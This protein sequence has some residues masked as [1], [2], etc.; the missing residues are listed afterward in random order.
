M[1]ITE[2]VSFSCSSKTD[3][4]DPL[5]A[6]RRISSRAWSRV[7][8]LTWTSLSLTMSRR[9]ECLTAWQAAGSS[10]RRAGLVLWTMHVYMGCV[11]TG[12]SPSSEADSFCDFIILLCEE[13]W[14]MHKY[15][16]NS[17]KYYC[18]LNTQM[19][20]KR[21]SPRSTCFIRLMGKFKYKN[22]RFKSKSK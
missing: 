21:N 3:V 6:M 9:G 10:G 12:A 19:G 14:Y 5:L 18:S 15:G 1:H 11:G 7:F 17:T 20:M 2:Q 13:V 4:S 16:F 8:P 22:T